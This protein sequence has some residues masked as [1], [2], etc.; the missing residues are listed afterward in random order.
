[1]YTG[2]DTK[3]VMNSREV[4]SKMSTIEATVNKMIYF[5]LFADIVLHTDRHNRRWEGPW[6]PKMGP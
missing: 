5:I 2:R 6:F 1:M 3:L 4:P